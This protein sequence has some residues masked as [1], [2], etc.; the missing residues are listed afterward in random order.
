MSFKEYGVKRGLS[1]K[2]ESLGFSEAFEVQKKVIPHALAKKEVAVRAK[3]GSSKTL[4]FGVPLAQMIEKTGKLQAMVLVPTRELAVQVNREIRK[5]FPGNIALIYGGVK[6]ERQFEALKHA[7]IVIGTPGRILDHIERKTLHG[8]TKF[9]VLDEA[10][11][12]L[13]MGFLPDVRRIMGQVPPEKVWLFSAT[14]NGKITGLMKGRTFKIIEIGEE[15]PQKTS[16][17]YV[18]VRR[19]I[20]K[21]RDM[22]NGHKTLIFCNTKGMT[23]RLSDTFK[24]PS[25]HG[26]MTQGAREKNLRKFREGAKYLVATD[27]AARGID[28]PE[29]E[30]V[31]NFDLPKDS[32]TY[33]HRC[34]RTGRAGNEGKVINMIRNDDHDAFRR[35]IRDL[36]LNMNRLD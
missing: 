7:D 4:A 9:L 36:R 2:L 8:K 6:Y 13:D 22:L 5:F 19:K 32:S 29:V 11:R 34:G 17:Y 24:I 18:D 26:N 33:V 1:N 28:V 31:I 23:Q 16:H 20:S 27:V 30:V 10:D 3:T 21:L 25:L 15:M 14:L 12:M 35:I